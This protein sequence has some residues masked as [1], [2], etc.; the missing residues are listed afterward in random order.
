MVA[1]QRRH[2]RFTSA[3]KGRQS[4][5]WV[6]PQ[7]TINKP[8]KKA[9]R[10]VTGNTK[11]GRNKNAI[12]TLGKQVKTLQNR[13]YG[14]LQSNTKTCLMSGLTNLPSGGQP[15]AFAVND[16]YTQSILKGTI[17][18]A[19]G[20]NIATFNKTGNALSPAVYQSDIDD[21]Y[22]WNARSQD[23]VSPIE[24]KPVFTRINIHTKVVWNGVSDGGT[25][26]I[27]VLK[28]KPFNATNKLDINLP[29]ALGAY[30][31]LC[32]PQYTDDKN[33]FNKK[34]HTILYDK[35]VRVEN[36]CRTSGETKNVEKMFS[37]P[38]R[39]GNQVLK[40][41][42]NNNPVGQEFWTNVPQRDQIWC[43]I[44]CSPALDSKISQIGMSKYDMWRDPHGTA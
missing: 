10:R 7:T 41:D 20:Q 34:F 21:C 5:T 17:T 13:V 14:E 6:K 42:F 40:P 38:V 37:I 35:T 15:I 30:R 32:W 39:Y 2:N 43:L 16:F 4:V 28:V 23:V 8:V 29:S 36:P 18:A 31:K 1:Y 26:R 27:T 44:S 22:E 19:A 33:F 3:A 25:F 11:T 12:M 9:L 24:Y